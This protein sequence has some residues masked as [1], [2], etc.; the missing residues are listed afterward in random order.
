MKTWVSQISFYKVSWQYLASSSKM[1][2]K[3]SGTWCYHK[4]KDPLLLIRDEKIQMYFSA[5]K[6][7]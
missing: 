5:G 4:C 3:I 6:N 2:K 7:L 1:Y